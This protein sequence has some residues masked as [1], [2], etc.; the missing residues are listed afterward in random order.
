MTPPTLSLCTFIGEIVK[1]PQ[2]NTV[3]LKY[4]PYCMGVLIWQKLVRLF[5][6]VS[7][8]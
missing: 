6:A 1:F 7:V 4:N 2:R 5:W 8:A 3:D